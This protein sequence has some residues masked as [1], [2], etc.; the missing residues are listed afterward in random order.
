MPQLNMTQTIHKA[1]PHSPEALVS[2][3]IPMYGV[4]AHLG[5]CLE[6]LKQQSYKR[7]ELIFVDD[8][9]PDRASEIIQEAR[10]LLEAEGFIVKLTRHERNRGV[11]AAR[12]TALDLATGEYIYSFDADDAMEP[13]LI[14]RMVVRAYQTGVDIVGCW[15]SLRYAGRDRKM[16]QPEVKTGQAMYEAMCSGVM[17]WNLW[18]FLFR[19]DL[20]ERGERLRFTEGDN[21]GEDMMLMCSLALRAE[22][23]SII[24]EHL[25]YYVKTNQS[26]QT[27]NYKPEHW[28]QVDRNLRTLESAIRMAGNDTALALIQ[29]LKLNLKLP[30]LV[31][32]NTQ[33]QRLWAKWYP[34]ANVA[35]M[36]NPH[37][38]LR[39]KLLQLVAAKGQW[40]LV[41]LYNIIITKYLYPLLYA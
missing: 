35:I 13:K 4:E 24:P 17:K 36:S 8:A 6:Q 14:E 34:E 19:R 21:M 18:L 27:A 31:S 20:L 39:I 10:P 41:R 22:R 30:L 9:S 12:N 40:W 29:R 33:E 7:L 23:V 26:A 16:S 32:L 25:Y 37:Q 5:A 11:A 2:V 28:G 1:R 15:W 38:S 3:I